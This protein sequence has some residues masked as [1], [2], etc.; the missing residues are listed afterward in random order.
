M[1]FLPIRAG[2]ETYKLLVFNMLSGFES[3]PTHQLFFNN[4]HMLEKLLVP[5]DSIFRV[6]ELTKVYGTGACH[7]EHS[8]TVWS[9]KISGVQ[10]NWQTSFFVPVP[11]TPGASS[12]GN[13]AAQLCRNC[14][15]EQSNEMH[16]VMNVPT[17]GISRL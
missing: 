11:Y 9:G 4:S 6:R 10:A 8:Q 2:N 7:D 15:A 12:N 14:H 3:R 17:T 13:A 16:G 5:N 1:R